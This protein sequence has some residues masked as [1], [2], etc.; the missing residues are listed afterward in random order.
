MSHSRTYSVLHQLTSTLEH[1]TVS[2]PRS[3][4]IPELGKV[5][6]PAS[7]VTSA[8]SGREPQEQKI[9]QAFVLG[10]KVRRKCFRLLPAVLAIFFKLLV[11]LRT[12]MRR[13]FL[14]THL[15]NFI[16]DQE[17]GSE[18]IH[19]LPKVSKLIHC[20]ARFTFQIDQTLNR[21]PCSSHVT[22]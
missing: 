10:E 13:E 18:Q 11:C 4:L 5:I 7:K 22:H 19:D 14:S 12:P 3:R 20:Q 16:R 6:D 8:A 21:A 15:S 1:P 2:L 9:K 17:I